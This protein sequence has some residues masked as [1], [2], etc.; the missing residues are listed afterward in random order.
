MTKTGL[1]WRLSKSLFFFQGL[2]PTSS[3]DHD[4]LSSPLDQSSD[5]QKT[6]KGR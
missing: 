5:Q 2:A 6:C 3:Q 4:S 1:V